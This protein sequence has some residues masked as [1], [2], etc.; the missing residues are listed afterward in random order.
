[1]PSQGF[2][3]VQKQTQSMVLAPQLRQS[4]K[5]LQVSALELRDVILEE[6][7]SNPTLEEL[8]MDGASIDASELPPPS[9]KPSSVENAEG[10]MEFGRE[11][12]EVFS[13]MHEDYRAAMAEEN[14]NY[15]YSSDDEERRKHFFDS[16]T[17]EASL[18]DE[19]MQQAKLTDASSGVLKA[20]EY[21]IGSLDDSG[22]LSSSVGDLALLSA[23]PLGDMQEAHRLLKSLEPAGIG[24]STCAN[25]F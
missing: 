7:Q 22:F 4:L 2:Q 11:D 10:E 6:L 5:I 24:A 3:Q 16:I 15:S 13:Q 23:L 19:L 21:M 17:S 25:V 20:L 12:F 9:D 18:Q 8:P 1:M 14:G